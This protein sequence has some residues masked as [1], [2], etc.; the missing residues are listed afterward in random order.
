VEFDQSFPKIKALPLL[1][2]ACL[3]PCSSPAGAAAAAALANASPESIASLALV[4][5]VSEHRVQKLAAMYPQVCV[6]CLPQRG[7]ARQVT[8][9]A[10]AAAALD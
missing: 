3:H 10:A 2:F 8:K 4:M 1:Q 6:C 5:L 7:G 9:L